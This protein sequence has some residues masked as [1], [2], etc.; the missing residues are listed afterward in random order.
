MKIVNGESGFWKAVEEARSL[1][2]IPLQ[3]NIFFLLGTI[4]L[5]FLVPFQKNL[6]NARD[7][8][9]HYL[10]SHINKGFKKK[11]V[12]GETPLYIYTIVIGVALKPG[13]YPSHSTKLSA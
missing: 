10:R 6:C 3:A 9:D 7:A 1:G 4:P 13:L 12:D 2:S 11:D 5:V 8:P